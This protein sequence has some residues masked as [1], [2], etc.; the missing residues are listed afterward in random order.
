VIHR[1][2]Q[3]KP[4]V[5]G[6]LFLVGS[7]GA[8]IFCMYTLVM[9]VNI[10]TSLQQRPAAS[11]GRIVS[12]HM[13][14]VASAI[15]DTTITWEDECRPTVQF[16]TASG[17]QI[18]F[19]SSF[20]GGFHQGDAVSVHYHPDQPQDALLVSDIWTHVE[21]EAFLGLLSL[22]LMVSFLISSL[23]RQQ[24]QGES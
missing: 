17:Q 8:L 13:E 21:I 1:R 7:A 19:V 10:H 6:I 11:Q 12:C 15:G 3:F 16:Q 2:H 4:S 9:A 23:R 14:S 5:E 22:P 18:A 20:T 24:S